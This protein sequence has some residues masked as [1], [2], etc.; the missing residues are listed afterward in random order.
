MTP[1]SIAGPLAR[2]APVLSEDTPLADA[3]RQLLD[4]GLPALPVVDAR[5]PLPRASS[6][7]VS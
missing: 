4:T 7:S 6:A 5:E 2:E 3:V 1:Q